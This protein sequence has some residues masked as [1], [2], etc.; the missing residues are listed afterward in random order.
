MTPFAST[1]SLAISVFAILGQALA[2]AIIAELAFKKDWGATRLARAHAIKLAFATA[3]SGLV[4]S[5]IY[6]DIIG[7]PPCSLCYIQRV[8][9]YP[10][11]L[12]LGYLLWKDSLHAW[13][14]ALGLSIAGA[15]IAI[16]HY[17]GQMF[18]SDALNC[19][20]GTDG[21]SLCAQVPFVQFGYITIPMLSLTA[22]VLIITLLIASRKKE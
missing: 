3:L 15:A 14:I 20:I 7:F 19:S 8:F 5:L 9:L 11:V 12:V 6:S 16:Y 17:Y 21:S 18:N 1:F 13:R 4:F 22:F 10:Q 2:I